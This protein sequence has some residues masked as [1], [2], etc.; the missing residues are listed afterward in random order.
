MYYFKTGNGQQNVT[1]HVVSQLYKA[2]GIDTP[3]MNL[4]AGPGFNNQI[5]IENCWIKSK[6]IAGLKPIYEDT[7]L[8]HEGFAV[9]AW[10]A[11]W[12][13]VCSGNTCIKNGSAVR[14]DFGGALNFRARGA[15]KNFGNQ[16]TELSTLL[17]PN[18]N[19]ESASVFK[20]MTREDLIKS[21]E[22][23]Q[24]VTNDDIQNL[25]NSVKIYMNPELFS[26]IQNRK[27]YMS[28]VL[29]EVRKMEIKPNETIFDYVKRVENAV[30]TKY[31]SKINAMNTESEKRVRVINDMIE[32]RNTVC[33]NED[34]LAIWDYKGSSYTANTCIQQGRLDDPLVTKLDVALDKTALSEDIVLYR[35]DHFIIDSKTNLRYA[36]LFPEYDGCSFGRMKFTENSAFYDPAA[37]LTASKWVDG[38]HIINNVAS[39]DEIVGRIF[40]KGKIV[41]E[42]QFV[43]TTVSPQVAKE[44]GS[45]ETDIIY[46]FK[47][48]KGTK[49]TCPEKLDPANYGG[50]ENGA[51]GNLTGRLEG[52]EAEILLKRGFSYRMD[53]LIKE[54]GQYIIECTILQ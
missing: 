10:L 15:K 39:M 12:D 16:V 54:N 6:A 4:V 46:R 47:A 18:I 27:T 30:N 13:A 3:D 11:N 21:L 24:S 43:S 50:K 5:G 23:V 19:P 49:A 20:N 7:K 26:T 35:G 29:N 9:D 2:A 36:N 14:L 8:A 34:N 1:E 40:K 31:S 22:R 28:Y 53:N 45:G 52:S 37:P 41:R 42:E 25:Y 32:Q 17:D 44:F 51:G 48:P 38:K 33:T